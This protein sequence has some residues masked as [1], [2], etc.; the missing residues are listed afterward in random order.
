[1]AGDGVHELF[2]YLVI[3]GLPGTQG[4]LQVEEISAVSHSQFQVTTLFPYRAGFLKLASFKLSMNFRN[5]F[6]YV[7]EK[8]ISFMW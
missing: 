8:S 6:C 3:R 2:L 4:I 5:F 7:D 1:M